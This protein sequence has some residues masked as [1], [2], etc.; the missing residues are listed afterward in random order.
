M[1]LSAEFWFYMNSNRI[2]C[3]NSIAFR[4]ILQMPIYPKVVL[5]VSCFIRLY[6]SNG[7]L[8]RI[9]FLK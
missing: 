8:S 7:M 4:I 1:P 5:F 6:L 2:T 9:I 3:F